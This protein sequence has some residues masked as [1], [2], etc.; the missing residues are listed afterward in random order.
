MHNSAFA[1]YMAQTIDGFS[2]IFSSK[3]RGIF[4]VF[5]IVISV[6]CLCSVRPFLIRPINKKYSYYYACWKLKHYSKKQENAILQISCDTNSIDINI[7]ILHAFNTDINVVK[8]DALN[9]IMQYNY[10]WS[11]SNKSSSPTPLSNCILSTESQV[12]SLLSFSSS[13]TTV[14]PR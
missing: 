10:N 8:K 6:H 2:D 12:D 1:C 7:I 11:Q 5:V 14:N 3:V 4:K 9:I 13:F